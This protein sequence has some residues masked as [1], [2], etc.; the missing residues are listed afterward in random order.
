[1]PDGTVH[2]LIVPGQRAIVARGG[3]GG[4]GNKR[5][6]S[7][8]RQAPRFAER[9]L[10]GEEGWIDLQLKLLADVGLVGLPNAGKSSL[11]SRPDARRAEGRRLPV[12][13]ARAACSACSRAPTASSSSPTSPGL[14]EG[15]SEGAGPRP[16]LPRA[17]RAHAAA[18][19]RARPRAARR[20]RPASRTS[21][22]IERE[23]E[24]ARP[25]ARAAAAH[26]RRC[27][28]P[29]SCRRRRRP[30][31]PRAWR[32]RLGEDV[33]GARHLERDRARASTSCGVLLLRRVPLDGAARRST[34]SSPRRRSPSTRS[35]GPPPGKAWHVERGRRGLLPRRRR[36][37]R[38]AARPLRRRERGGA[39][40]RRAPPA[41]HGRDPRARGRRASSPATT[42]RSPASSSSSTRSRPDAAEPARAS[43]PTSCAGGG[44]IA[45]PTTAGA[46]A[47]CT[48]RPDAGP[49]PVV[50]RGARRLVEAGYDRRVM[51][52][53]C[54]DLVRRG[55]AAWNVEYRRMGGGQGGGWPATFDGRRGRRG[56]ARRAATRRW[57]WTASC[58]SGT[59]RAGTSRSGPRAATGC[60]TARRAPGRC[61]A[62]A[63][64]SPRRRSPT[65]SAR[66]SLIA[67]GGLVNELLGG[68]PDDGARALRRSRTRRGRCRSACPRCSST[69]P[70]TGRSPSGRAATTPPRRARRARRSSSSSRR[71]RRT[72]PTSTRGRAAWAAVTG[73]L[74]ALA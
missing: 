59:A 45:T 51:R 63:R 46:S 16:R 20:L 52:P 48:C 72:A 31:R 66:A 8:T 65:S 2:D 13:D 60:R 15:A 25:A 64:S 68:G 3:T 22:T 14:I 42:W 39:R 28:R 53:V 55:W 6:T 47:S 71:A 23:L 38:A 24:R 37:R 1:M 33:P 43:P 7:P 29:T 69:A 70:R 74:A 17:R 11:L 61:C 30:R 12:H 41:A 36:P 19:P 35:S 73:R 49:H 44:S 62:R 27:R 4:R 10:P 58:C 26:P 32:E 54:R 67:P 5:F 34:T 56:R 21:P 9:G 50:D 40:P 18:R 57:T